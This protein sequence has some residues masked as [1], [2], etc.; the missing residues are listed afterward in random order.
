MAKIRK[1]RST[2]RDKKVQIR[3]TQNEYFML[4][5]K[6]KNIGTSVS[7]LIRNAAKKT[8]T[9]TA[10]DKKIEQEKNRQLAK[11]GN[12][13]NQIARAVNTYKT[14]IKAAEVIEHLIVIENEIRRA[15]Q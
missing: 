7:D 3:L 12:N 11:I 5:E 2:I 1:D 9:W 4:C 10:Q 15:I 8:R 13:L 6:A 14:E